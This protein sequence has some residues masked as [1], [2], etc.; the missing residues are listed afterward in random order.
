VKFRC[1]LR[2]VILCAFCIAVLAAG[3][4]SSKGLGVLSVVA[5]VLTLIVNAIGSRVDTHAD[6]KGH[7][8]RSSLTFWLLLFAPML[9]VATESISQAIESIEVREVFWFWMKRIVFALIVT[10]LYQSIIVF[11]REAGGGAKES[12]IEGRDR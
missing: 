5:Y 2:S 6:T 10:A 4:A 1:G 3:F 9:M 7:F 8:L 11:L 12:R